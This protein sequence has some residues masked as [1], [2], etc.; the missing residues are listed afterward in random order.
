[1]KD[2]PPKRLDGLC[3]L[4]LKK[5]AKTREGFCLP[6]LRIRICE[7]PE[8]RGD[9]RPTICHPSRRHGEGA[10]GDMSPFQEN[11]IRELEDSP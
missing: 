11:A 9:T 6:C 4:C 8:N 3:S 5:E 1:M 10:G 7:L 2:I